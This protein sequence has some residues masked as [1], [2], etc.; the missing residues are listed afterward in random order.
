MNYVQ[1][2]PYQKADGV[3]GAAMVPSYFFT[4]A[5]RK[6]PPHLPQR[7]LLFMTHERGAKENILFIYM[8]LL[9][10]CMTIN[11]NLSISNP[12]LLC[13]LYSCPHT[14]VEHRNICGRS[15]S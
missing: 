11:N 3:L 5:Y 10:A 15:M 7:D 2:M 8:H 9:L 14:S 1:Y 6:V 12:F 13:L 4:P